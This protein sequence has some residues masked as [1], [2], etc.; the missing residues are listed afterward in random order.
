MHTTRSKDGTVIAFERSGHGP[1]IILVD[2]ALCY[3][4]SGPSRP[5]AALLSERFTVY[6]YDRRGRGDSGDTLPYAPARDFTPVSNLVTFPY[7]LVAHPSVP[8]R[9]S[10]RK[11]FLQWAIPIT[12]VPKAL[13][14]CGWFPRKQVMVP[15]RSSV[16]GLTR[17]SKSTATKARFRPITSAS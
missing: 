4:A 8:A 13:L 15:A 11:V 16:S 1:A 12:S 14:A 9:N 7:I 10:K 6:W 17:S 5:L 3:R 2:G